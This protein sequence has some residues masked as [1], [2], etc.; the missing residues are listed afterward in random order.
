MA[1]K[2][3]NFADKQ[4]TQYCIP[5]WLRDEQIKKNLKA[6]K[7]R[8]QPSYKDVTG[9]IAVVA[10]GPSLEDNWEELK[11]YNTIITCSGAHRYLLDRGI[12]P[13]WHLEV[14]PREH[15]VD[16]LGTPDRNVTYL[17]ASTCHPDYIEHLKKHKCSIKLWHVFS[18]EEEAQRILPAGEWALTGGANVGLRA[19]VMA[20]FLGYK[21][22]TVFG[23][24]GNVRGQQSH[25]TE[26]PKYTK[27][28]YHTVEYPE[29]SGQMWH[30]T[31]SMLECAKQ[32]PYEIDQLVDVEISFKGHGLVQEMM[33]TY[34]RDPKAARTAEIAFSRPVTISEGYRKLNQQLHKDNLAYGVGAGKYANTVIQLAEKLKTTSILDYGCGKGYLGKA[35]PFP[36]WEY[37]P[38]IENKTDTPRPADIVLSFDV[39]EHIEPDKLEAVLQDLQRCIKKVGYFIIHTGPSSKNLSDGRNSHLIQQPLEWWKTQLEKYFMVASYVDKAPL[40]HIVVAKKIISLVS[41]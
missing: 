18:N 2:K 24:D 33:K 6:V 25:T 13:T 10:F 26:H 11:N 29:G 17:I 22:I 32:T 23:M 40:I 27:V 35:L 37:D 20:R 41:V 1:N 39:L 19:I 34:V 36:I 15:K 38:A 9:D 8:V 21:K 7:G 28:D 4:K 16:L 14:D 5:L 31:P 30:T 12:V 3:L